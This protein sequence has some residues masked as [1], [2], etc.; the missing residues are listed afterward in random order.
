MENRKRAEEMSI[1]E[2]AS[3]IDHSVL[4]PEFT[5]SQIE[6]EITRG[7]EYGCKTVCINPASLPIAERLCSGTKTGICVVCDFPFGQSTTQS[8]VRQTE[9]LCCNEVVND[10]DVVA[11]YGWI[12]SGQWRWFEDELRLLVSLCH[13]YH[14]VLKV[15]F[16]TDALTR[17]EIREATDRAATCGVDYVK[18][19][20]GFY[21]GGPSS[22]AS[23]EVISLMLKAAGGRCKVKG[24]GGIRN[25]SHFLELINLGVDR[26]GIGYKSTPVVLELPESHVR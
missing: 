6:L 26:M 12:K 24:S 25:R 1:Q 7:I 15:I 16:E 3:Y 19:S 13:E 4:K 5:Q 10:I 21:T 17:E 20:T 11:N 9:I 23:V 18:S 2:L 14:K 22:G 8:K